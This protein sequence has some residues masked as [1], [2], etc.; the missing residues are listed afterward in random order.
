[1]PRPIP[2][3][4]DLFDRFLSRIEFRA[5]GCW[6]WTEGLDKDGY[7]RLWMRTR[8]VRAHRA[9]FQFFKGVLDT[10]LHILHRCD[11]PSCV[12]PAHLWSGTNN[13][14]VSD[15]MNKGRHRWVTHPKLTPANVNDI[16]NCVDSDK[17][18]AAHFGV[19]QTTINRI[20]NGRRWATTGGEHT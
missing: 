13:D 5:G 20:R 14:N 12:N 9:S 4:N 10:N 18:L 19:H 11:N 3:E 15:K 6:D 2:S 8:N 7:G 1:M 16:R 17:S